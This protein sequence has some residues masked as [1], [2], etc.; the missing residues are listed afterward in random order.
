VGEILLENMEFYAY[1]GHY[2]EEQKIGCLFR[3]TVKIDTDLSKSS[4]T[5]ILN[6]TIDYNRIYDII[7]KE[8]QIPSKLLEHVAGRI[9]NAI[10]ANFK[11]IEKV[12]LKITKIN[13]PL[14][15]KI[16]GVSIILSS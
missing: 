1:H 16:E 11:Q 13:P 4:K 12:T 6:D 9:I 5:D 8:M 3:V 7:K 14:A 2:D 10:Y 15:G